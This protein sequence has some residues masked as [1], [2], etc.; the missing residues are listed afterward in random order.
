MGRME[1]IVVRHG[2]PLRVENEDGTPADP[3]LSETGLGQA[4]RT[5][6]FLGGE[7]ID[8][9][10]CS[11]L[12]RARQTA[13]PLEA[14][15]GHA[16]QIEPGVAEFDQHDAR[17]VPLE[18]L[19]RTDPERYRAL[20]ASGFVEQFDLPAFQ[21]LVV[22]T[23]ERIIED[24]PGR[25]VV[26]VCHGGVINAWAAHVLRLPSPLFFQPHYTSL[27]RFA[28][29]SAGHRSVLSLNETAHLR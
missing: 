7:R 3:P 19:K 10:Y 8:R 18:E 11:P 20:L 12:L 26:V 17:Y 22:A 15:V 4:E 27:N 14:R 23:L 13:A 24:N 1:L 29:S 2:L 9:L 21:A 16:A 5:A 6:Q 28:A 25:R